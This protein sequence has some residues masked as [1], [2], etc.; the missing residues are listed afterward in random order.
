MGNILYFFK[1]WKKKNEKTLALIKEKEKQRNL[2]EIERKKN[3]VKQ[4][5]TKIDKF[6]EEAKEI[7]KK[8][9]KEEIKKIEIQTNEKIKEEEKKNKEEKIALEKDYKEMDGEF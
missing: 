5:N 1:H 3:E 6:I 7:G 4:I 2:Q 8:E 9:A